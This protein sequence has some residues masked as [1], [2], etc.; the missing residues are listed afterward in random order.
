MDNP[1]T[2]RRDL[3]Q[4]LIA[5][6][7]QGIQ[8]NALDEAEKLLGA[9]RLLNPELQGLEEFSSY[10]AIKRGFVNEALQTYAAAPADNSKWYVMMALCLKLSGDPTW[11]WHA[12]QSLERQDESARYAHNLAN[13]LLGNDAAE[14]AVQPV[15][16]A[17]PAAG[18]QGDYMHYLAV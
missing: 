5:I 6:L 10:I 18:T 15:P 14:P 1:K 8:D 17:V 3:L 13:I 12:M 16:A 7:S 4:A 11:H 2:V 9:I